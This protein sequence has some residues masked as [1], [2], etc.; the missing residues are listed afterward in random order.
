LNEKEKIAVEEYNYVKSKTHGASGALSGFI[1][2]YLFLNILNY[3]KI[4]LIALGFHLLYINYESFLQP[5]SLM[6]GSCIAHFGGMLGGF[7][8]VCYYWL[9]QMKNKNN[10]T[11]SVQ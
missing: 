4:I 3:R 8:F 6:N 5:S 2:F 11:I 1:V 10:E 7:L 9:Y